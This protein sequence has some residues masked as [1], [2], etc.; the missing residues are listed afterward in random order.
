MPRL[1]AHVERFTVTSA[2]GTR[3]V[4]GVEGIHPA[5]YLRPPEPGALVVGYVSR[6]VAHELPLRDF[7]AYLEEEG[8]AAALGGLRPRSGGGDRV[9]E[10]FSRC[11]KAL[12]AVGGELGAVAETALGCELELV[13]ELSHG[14]P[15]AARLLL[16]GRPLAGARVLLMRLGGDRPD[17]ELRTDD[18]GRVALPPT[19]EAVVLHAVHGEPAAGALDNAALPALD[20]TSHWASLTLR[21]PAPAAVAT[22]TVAAPSA[23][24]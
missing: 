13:P 7:V 23:T 21:L 8:L 2:L 20:W 18:A 17:V 1:A 9:A 10:T 12:V 16:R 4:A 11:A 5:G 15:A 24:R 3:E 19:G 6:P 22:P 14:A